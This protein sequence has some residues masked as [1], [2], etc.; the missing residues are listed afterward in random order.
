MEMLTDVRRKMCRY[1]WYRM[2]HS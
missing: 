1:R 2:L